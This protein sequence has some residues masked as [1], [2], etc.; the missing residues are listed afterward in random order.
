[1]REPQSRAD[2]AQ[3]CATRLVG[4][5]DINGN[6]CATR[7]YFGFFH[8]AFR[9]GEIRDRKKSTISRRDAVAQGFEVNDCFVLFVTLRL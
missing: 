3:L 6:V 5:A 7:E 9:G 4:D 1:M 8:R 2:Y